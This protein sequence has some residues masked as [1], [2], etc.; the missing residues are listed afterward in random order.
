MK[1]ILSAVLL[2]LVPAVATAAE[3]PDW[4][5]PVAPQGLPR[6]DPSKVVT[7]PGSDKKY[8]E[9]EVNNPFG[10]PDWFPAD[11]APLPKTVAEG[12]R[13]AVRAC[14]L[15]HLATGDGHP[16]SS[17]IAGLHANYIVRQLNEF[18]TEGRK[19]I[20]TT[21]MAEISKAITDE[22]AREAAAYF[23]ERKP[24]P[25][26]TKV[27]ESATVPKSYVGEGAMRFEAKEGGTEPIGNRIIVLPQN[28][29]GARA[30]NPRTGFVSYVPAGSVAKG[31]ELATTGGGGK[32][33][34]CTICHGQGLKGIGE[35]PAIANRDPIYLYRQLNDMQA[36][37][38]SGTSMA[39]MKAVVE[40]LTPDDMLALAAY[41]GS[42]EP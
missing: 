38:R 34:T 26:Y 27:V 16:E 36:G 40:K 30:R 24:A 5:Y 28:D 3:F 29:E 21:A 22:E 12:R 7:V 23:A 4:A 32:T 6:P 18:K 2:A 31:R 39:L 19:G 33:L 13:P 17:G 35:V 37:M 14:G 15:C 20:R 11:H 8:T 10:P 25:G 1:A 41:V 42:L 9:V